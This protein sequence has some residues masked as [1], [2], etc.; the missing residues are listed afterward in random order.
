[1]LDAVE[2]LCSSRCYLHYRHNR[3]D[4]TIN[5]AAQEELAARGIATGAGAGLCR[6]NG[7]GCIFAHAKAVSRNSSQL[8]DQVSQQPL[9]ALSLLSTL[10]VARFQR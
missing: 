6:R 2:F 1:M 9:F 7:C 10:A 5:W 4:N 8:L 3:D